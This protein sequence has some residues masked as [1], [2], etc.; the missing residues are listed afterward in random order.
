VDEAAENLK[1]LRGK[2]DTEREHLPSFLAVITGT[3]YAYRRDDGV[4][5][6]PLGCLKD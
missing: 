3:E 5:V 1:K 6:V 2:I 4:F